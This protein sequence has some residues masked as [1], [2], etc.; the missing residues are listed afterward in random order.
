MP[1]VIRIWDHDRL[2]LVVLIVLTFLFERRWKMSV[3]KVIEMGDVSIGF[4]EDPAEDREADDVAFCKSNGKPDYMCWAIVTAEA[5][6]VG[7]KIKHM[8]TDLLELASYK[9]LL[10]S[11]K[12]DENICYPYKLYLAFNWVEANGLRKEENYPFET[13]KGDC[14]PKTEQ[15]N[16]EELIKAADKQPVAGGIRLSDEF[17]ALKDMQCSFVDEQR[18][19]FFQPR[20]VDVRDRHS[21]FLSEHCSSERNSLPYGVG[22]NQRHTPFWSRKPSGKC[23]VGV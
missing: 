6:A 4:P 21:C 11:C 13:E 14:K 12:V 15:E 3:D 23:K 16:E 1:L 20:R 22:Q 5:V 7:Y 8:E 10:D 9:E 2:L 19:M 17:R 18:T